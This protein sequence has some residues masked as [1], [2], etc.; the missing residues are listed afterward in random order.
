MVRLKNRPDGCENCPFC[1]VTKG[2]F[3]DGK[4][5]VERQ[6]SY[7]GVKR[8]DADFRTCPLD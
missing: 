6:K 1:Y 3:H 7:C 2:Y 4:Q 8:G 5:V